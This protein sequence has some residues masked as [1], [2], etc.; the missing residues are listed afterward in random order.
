MSKDD[1]NEDG[2]AIGGRFV[3]IMKKVITSALKERTRYIAQGYSD[4]NKP[5]VVQDTSTLRSS[6]ISVILSVSVVMGFRLFSHDVTQAYLQSTYELTR[7]VY[8]QPKKADMYVF[9]L[10]SDELFESSKPLYGICEAGD[11]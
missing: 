8:V 10:K 11:Y 1:I 5:Y 2:L 4:G 7:K 6:Y 9:G 3:L